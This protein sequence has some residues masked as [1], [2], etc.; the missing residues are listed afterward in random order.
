[1]ILKM[2]VILG[3]GPLSLDQFLR[4]ISSKLANSDVSGSSSTIAA[5]PA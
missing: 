2:A 3:H 1:M 5:N 4:N